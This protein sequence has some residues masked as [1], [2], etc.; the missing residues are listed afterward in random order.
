MKRT[1]IMTV[2]SATLLLSGCDEN[3]GTFQQST[4][5]GTVSNDFVEEPLTKNAKKYEQ[6]LL[7]SNRFLDLWAEK[8]F[9]EIHDQLIDP[10]LLDDDK[11]EILSVEKL[12]DI[13]KNVEEAFG[14]MV[15][16]KKMQWAFEPKRKKKQYFL[17]SIK[18]VQHEKGQANYLFQFLLDGGFKKLIG[19]YVRPKPTL[20]APGQIHTERF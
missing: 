3:E 8:K 4:R 7:L 13:H 11:Q 18:I 5:S 10:E 9:Q 2:L 20:R 17:F 12:A 19:V 15:G 6:A 1:V 16:Y 14:P